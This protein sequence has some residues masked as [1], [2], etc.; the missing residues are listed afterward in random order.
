MDFA[1]VEIM[2][3]FFRSGLISEPRLTLATIQEIEAVE[4]HLKASFPIGYLE[5]VTTL[6]LGEYCGFIRIDMPVIIL[7]TYRTYQNVL[8]SSWCWD[9]G[10]EILPKEKA[11]EL[12][13]IGDTV[14]G[15]SIIFHSSNSAELFVLP[16]KQDK[17]HRIGSSVYEAIDWLCGLPPYATSKMSTRRYF[18][19]D[20]ALQYTYD[21][22]RSA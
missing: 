6:G 8:C 1:D 14:D 15:D 19:P 3:P 4:G 18:V 16:K 7:A 12:I 10:R 22:L 17:P 9:R 21:V 13:K 20:R 2:D 11:A 5:Y